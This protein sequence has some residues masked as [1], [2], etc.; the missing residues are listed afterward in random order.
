MYI[1]YLQKQVHD[2]VYQVTVTKER[3][4]QC[5]WPER[6]VE[7]KESNIMV[8]QGT[9]SFGKY[10]LSY[11]WCWIWWSTSVNIICNNIQS[12]QLQFLCRLVYQCHSHTFLVYPYWNQ[13]LHGNMLWYLFFFLFSSFLATICGFVGSVEKVFKEQKYIYMLLYYFVVFSLQ[14][15]VGVDQGAP[16]LLFNIYI[17]QETPTDFL[18][19]SLYNLQFCRR[20]ASMQF[21]GEAIHLKF[22]AKSNWTRLVRS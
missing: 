14:V 3:V 1:Q 21:S 19:S 16:S 10:S 8:C 20:M 6:F 13:H 22:V 18:T 12:Q 4:S 15:L 5:N 17:L 2:T 11:K 7:N 9:G